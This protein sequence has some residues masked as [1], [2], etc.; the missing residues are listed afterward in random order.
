MCS[1][2][3]TNRLNAAVLGFAPDTIFSAN[4]RSFPLPLPH[5]PFGYQPFHTKYEAGI[6]STAAFISLLR[7]AHGFLHVGVLNRARSL[8]PS[9]YGRR[10][11]WSPLPWPRSWPFCNTS[12]LVSIGSCSVP[13]EYS[14]GPMQV[15][16]QSYSC[17]TRWKLP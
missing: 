2:T 9:R 6:T 12:C 14:R 7:L 5:H 4:S 16:V 8:L 15:Q 13:A 11:T 3:L 1:L 10:T 17:G